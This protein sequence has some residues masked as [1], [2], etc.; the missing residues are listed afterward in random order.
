MCS[1]SELLTHEIDLHHQMSLVTGP[2]WG[3]QWQIIN[4][5]MIVWGHFRCHC[6]HSSCS[7]TNT[8]G[9]M[10]SWEKSNSNKNNVCTVTKVFYSTSL[11]LLFSL[12]TNSS[13]HLWPLRWSLQTDNECWP[14][15]DWEIVWTSWFWQKLLCRETN[16]QI[17]KIIFKKKKIK[18]YLEFLLWIC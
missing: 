17:K 9:I 6:R 18:F 13:M 8:T 2:V 3:E 10:F 5:K 11:L 12:I 15:P 16:L 7:M 14:A 4:N 1:M